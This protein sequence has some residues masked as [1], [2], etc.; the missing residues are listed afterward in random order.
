MRRPICSSCEFAYAAPV[1][2][3]ILPPDRGNRLIFGEGL[4]ATIGE[5]TEDLL[6]EACVYHLI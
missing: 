1:R 6:N 5:C 2:K 3:L 4:L